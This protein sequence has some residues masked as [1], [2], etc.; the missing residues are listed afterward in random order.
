MKLPPFWTKDSRS[1]F[2]LAESTFNRC[3]VADPWLRFDLVLPALPEEVIEQIR[4]ILH[5][6]DN[7]ANPYRALKIRM[8]DL[9]TPKPL[10]QCQKIIHGGKLGD[11]RHSQLMESMLA[12]LPPGE[13]DGMLFKTH[14]INRLPLD[15]RDHVVAGSFNLSSR[16]MAAVADNLWIARNSHQS[17][18]K[19]HLVVAAVQE[20]VEEVEVAVAELNVQPKKKAAKGGKS[21][22]KLCH[23]KYGDQTWKSADP[24]TCTWSG[25]E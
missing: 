17:G 24:C 15:I 18:N 13:P 12:L 16:E 1:W 20:D 21:Q 14:F 22:G 2:T 3:G 25:N 11:R 7:I 4:G 9:F 8:L 5:A 19:H 23:L 10:D 6:V